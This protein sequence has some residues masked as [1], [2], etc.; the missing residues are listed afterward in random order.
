MSPACYTGVVKNSGGTPIESAYVWMPYPGPA[1]GGYTGSDG[2]FSVCFDAPTPV[3]HSL[4][5]F[6]TD[7]CTPACADCAGLPDNPNYPSVVNGQTVDVGV[8]TITP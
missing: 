5:A 7:E 1:D 4:Y 3:H 8:I 2:R 6:C